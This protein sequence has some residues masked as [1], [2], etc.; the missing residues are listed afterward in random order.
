MPTPNLK[1]SITSSKMNYILFIWNCDS[2]NVNTLSDLIYP[3]LHLQNHYFS[4][5][6][7]RLC[8]MLCA[9]QVC[10][11]MSSYFF[12]AIKAGHILFPFLCLGLVNSMSS[13]RKYTEF[14]SDGLPHEHSLVVHEGFNKSSLWA[15]S[16]LN[17][18]PATWLQTWLSLQ[19]EQKKKV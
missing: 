2:Q 1:R 11:K 13:R 8:N 5:Y 17:R 6:V 10:V 14:F 18:M 4:L 3:C 9:K 7:Q 19:K 15:L 16:T 12:F